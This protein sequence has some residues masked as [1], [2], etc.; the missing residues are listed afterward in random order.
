MNLKEILN[1]KNFIKEIVID[2]ITLKKKIEELGKQITDDYKNEDDLIAICVLR[3]S[4]MFFTDLV[5]QIKIPIILDFIA[6]ESYGN[7]KSSSGT[8][9]IL[10][11][12]KENI[13]G[14]NVL[15]VDDIVDTGLTFAS[16]K[17]TLLAKRPK[18]LKFC[19]L[20]TKPSQIIVPVDINYQGFEIENKFV[21][22]YGLDYSEYFRNLN[23]I[24]VPDDKILNKA[25]LI[26]EE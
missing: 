4:V 18:T 10:K 12:I 22:G 23:F 19:T 11:D 15:L 24:F 16:L 8:V 5:R 20:I 13:E 25:G 9:R 3:G 7:R 21:V 26:L 1:N 2:E 6:V 17:D 14:K